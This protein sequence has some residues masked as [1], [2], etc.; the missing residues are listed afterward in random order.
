MD[1]QGGQ[2]GDALHQC[3][4]G[5]RRGAAMASMAAPFTEE[6]ARRSVSGRM[7]VMRR[8]SHRNIRGGGGLRRK[9]EECP[10]ASP[11]GVRQRMEREG[12]GSGQNGR[13]AHAL[14]GPGFLEDTKSQQVMGEVGVVGL[15]MPKVTSMP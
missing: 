4:A 2:R 3:N 9:G 1:W 5:A 15:P 7:G 14:G 12:G 10:C 13:H 8:L 11:E 6:R